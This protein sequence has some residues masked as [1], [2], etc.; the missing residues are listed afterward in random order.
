M[1]VVFDSNI[2]ISALVLPGGR[3]EEALI[4]I[5]TGLDPLIISSPIINEVLSVLARKFNKDGEALSRAAVHL[6]EISELVSP[7]KRV[8]ILADEPD[9]RIL[10]CAVRGKAAVIVTGDK[11]MLALKEYRGIR[12]VSL[13]EYLEEAKL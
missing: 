7:V 3:A 8:A 5:L 2:F 13:G 12:I 9:N 10:E 11:G 1:R 4:R 6:A